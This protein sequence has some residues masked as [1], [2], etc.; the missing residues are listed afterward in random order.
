MITVVTM[1][2]NDKFSRKKQF[3]FSARYNKKS[4][5]Q[6]HDS[7]VRDYMRKLGIKQ[8]RVRYSDWSYVNKAM[9]KGSPYR[10]PVPVRIQPQR[11]DR[12][13]RL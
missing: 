2:Y 10:Y 13:I 4:Q 12:T 1:R 11:K 3:V 9:F 7:E 6:S 8:C 5:G